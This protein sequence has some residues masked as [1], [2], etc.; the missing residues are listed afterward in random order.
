MHER[1]LQLIEAA[2]ELLE[3]H[4]PMTVRQLF[5]QL[6]SHQVIAN[7]QKEYKS[8]ARVLGIA[9]KRGLIPWEF[10][11]DRT[12]RP[13]KPPAWDSLETF[14]DVVKH[15]YRRDIW[16]VQPGY[17]EVWVEK[18]AL[19]GIFENI[20]TR[21][22]VTLQV[23]RGY[24]SLS[25]LHDAASRF[26]GGEV[27]YFGDFDPSGEDIERSIGNNLDDFGSRPK[28][29][30]V[31]I[32]REDIDTYNLPPIPT[33]AT[34]TRQAAFVRTH[35]DVA[36]ELD[37]LPLPVLQDRIKQV[38]EDRLDMNAYRNTRYAEIA[39]TERLVDALGGIK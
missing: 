18:D 35:G 8:A 29:T 22:G 11:E 3:A 33:K 37:A 9:R 31:A 1:T 2:R 17:F 32:N 25:A 7:T 27:L 30:R 21:Y 24:P 4:N 16:E 28:I 15:S 26:D 5:Y 12:R 38:I 20:T 13:L 39:D 14:I 36:V 19:S 23:V 34:D 10:I 6:V